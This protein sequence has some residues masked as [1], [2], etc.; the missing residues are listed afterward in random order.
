MEINGQ[1]YLNNHKIP[2]KTQHITQIML[3][4]DMFRLVKVI[5]RL[6]LNHI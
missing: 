1:L 2:V 3:Y 4:S 6:P 5:I